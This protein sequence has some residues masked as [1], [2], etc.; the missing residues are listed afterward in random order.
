MH[1]DA[2]GLASGVIFARILEKHGLVFKKDF[3]AS[4]VKD[5][6][7][8]EFLANQATKDE[9][10]K[11]DNIVL[12]DYSFPD[13]SSLEDK[14][15]LIIDHHQSGQKGK[16]YI[17]NPS[18]ELKSEDIPSNSAI[19]Y[20]LYYSLFGENKLLKQ[21]AFV[22]AVSDL[23][24][25]SSLKYLH[26]D[27]NDLNLFMKQSI[28]I[29]PIIFDIT[30]KLQD[31]YETINDNSLFEYLLKTT[32]DNLHS[33]FHFNKE[34]NKIILN[35][36]K[37]KLDTIEGILNNIEIN[38]E[39]ELIIVKLP[40]K[41]NALKKH[42]LNILDFL[43]SDFTKVLYIK[44]SDSFLCSL[45]SPKLNLVKLLSE[46]K[47]ELPDLKGGGHSFAAGCVVPVDKINLFLKALKNS[48]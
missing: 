44:S 22:G 27:T 42:L 23:M 5:S 45:R 41:K 28:V 16:D 8:Y 48:L 34:Y 35:V 25:Y 30:Q 17:L 12:L 13:Y 21:I 4:V 31:I 14:N 26:T 47:K 20:N 29:K 37:D 40:N 38:E 7:R 18:W 36:E 9:I 32:K 46:I 19:V 6:F 10:K 1:Y 33:L 11:Y 3:F 43:Y 39:K 2:D 15:I 24:P